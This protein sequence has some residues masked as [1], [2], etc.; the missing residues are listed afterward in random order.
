MAEVARLEINVRAR[1]GRAIAQLKALNQQIGQVNRNAQV[2]NQASQRLAQQGLRQL[3]QGM[4]NTRRSINSN[5]RP[6]RTFRDELNSS[7]RETSRFMG[8]VSRATSSLM[9]L[10][11]TFLLFSSFSLSPILLGLTG[12]VGSLT[13]VLGVATVSLGAFFAAVMGSE[14]AT[15]AVDGFKE[16]WRDWQES[17]ADIAA[18]PVEHFFDT[19]SN[20]L[21]QLNPLVETTSGIL[22]RGSEALARFLETDQFTSWLDD[23][24]EASEDMLPNLGSAFGDFLVGI[25][26][27]IRAFI[28]MGT[29]FTDW[30]RESAARFRRWSENLADS[31]GFQRFS[32]W[33]YENAPKIIGTIGDI[34]GAFADIV[35]SL[36]DIGMTAFDVFGSVAEYIGD[37]DS[38]TILTFAG[39]ILTLSAASSGL[40][41]ISGLAQ[42]LAG[43]GPALAAIGPQALV[44]GIIAAIAA[45]MY[46][47]WQRSEQFRNLI[48]EG[49]VPALQDIWESFKQ[50]FDQ[51]GPVIDIWLD[52]IVV[53]ATALAYYITFWATIYSYT[54]QIVSIIIEGW[55]L[56]FEKT[57]EIWGSLPGVAQDALKLMLGLISLPLTAIYLL[58]T[59]KWRQIGSFFSGF[60]E[61]IKSM[62]STAISYIAR[63]I[64]NWIGNIS[65][66]WDSF[67][68]ALGRLWSGFWRGIVSAVSTGARAVITGFLLLVSAIGRIFSGAI[69][70]LVSAGKDI[71]RGLWNGIL[72]MKDWLMDKVGGIANSIKDKFTGLLDIFSPSRV[73]MQYGVFI[74]KGLGIGMDRSLP[75][76]DQQSTQMAQTVMQPFV[77]LSPT[78]PMISASAPVGTG[79]GGTEYVFD[80]RGAMI[81]GG[82]RQMEDIVVKALSEAERKGRVRGLRRV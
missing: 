15:A 47:A 36:K 4:N 66:L 30:L 63:V 12:L 26:E 81:T 24:R 70:W 32:D 1:V 20:N 41:F 13:S 60:W 73:F 39:A 45:A 17:L 44:I 43:I 16:S 46:L 6:I 80:F 7:I 9:G 35:W 77:G 65:R 34:L 61:G 27:I 49:L 50:L 2:L 14:R 5:T 72:S 28:P 68:R 58:F 8:G 10:F 56:I 23:V 42:A 31:D 79:G 82:E 71:I 57:A 18:P 59:G 37:L 11:T 52:W 76:V 51:M 48:K 62:V 3:T 55:N 29:S 69:N 53:L 38:K 54:L 75:Y 19:L 74:G 21:S 33:I 78:S 67:T 40:G 64:G 25:M 22:L